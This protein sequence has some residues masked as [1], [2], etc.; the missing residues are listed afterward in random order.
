M[1]QFI[2]LKNDWARF[3]QYHER[4]PPEPIIE[5]LKKPNYL[6]C[7][8]TGLWITED[9]TAHARVLLF[10]NGEISVIARHLRSAQ[11]IIEAGEQRMLVA[12]QGRNR[13]LELTRDE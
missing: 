7:T 6:L 11:T 12:E 3:T 5:G 2:F 9:A 10:V 4:L 1:G 8:A 13:I